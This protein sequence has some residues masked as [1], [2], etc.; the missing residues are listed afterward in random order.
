MYRSIRTQAIVIR[1][2]RFGE[3][4]KSLSLLTEDL[5]LINATAYGA[6]KSQSRLRLGSEPFT[7]SAANLYH[8][9]VR[10]SYKVMELEIHASFEGLQGDLSRLASASLWAEVVQKSFGAGELTGGLFGLFRDSLQLLENADA[11]RESYVTIQFLWRFLGLA[12]YQ[13]DPTSCDSCGAPLG[14]RGPAWY[15]PQSHAL[16]CAA[17]G[18]HTGLPLPQGA[19]RYLAA[20]QEMPL[21][22]AADITMEEGSRSSLRDT[23]LGMVQSVLEGSLASLPW[24]RAGR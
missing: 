9:P 15:A 4:H 21:G 19:L 14:E 12:G 2:E 23:L 8:N 7:W 11:G 5:G 22:K 18:A 10:K 20:T 13:P 1:R 24:M 6:Y 16:Q 3:F 17:C